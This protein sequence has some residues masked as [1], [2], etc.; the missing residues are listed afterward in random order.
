MLGQQLRDQALIGNIAAHEMVTGIALQASQGFQ[1]ARIGEL[2]DIDDRL[3]IWLRQPIEHEIG[4]DEAGTTS[5]KEGHTVSCAKPA[6]QAWITAWILGP[7]SSRWALNPLA[8]A[9]S[10][11]LGR[12]LPHA[13]KA[14]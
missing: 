5:H 8:S 9:D 14:P 13:R 3:G 12:R 11:R 6:N 4:A 7:G 1:I 2:V 10:G